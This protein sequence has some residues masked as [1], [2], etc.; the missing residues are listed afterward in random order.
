EN[1][2]AIG[3]LFVRKFFEEQPDAI[4]HRREHRKELLA[5]F[6]A[7]V[8]EAIEI[9]LRHLKR[10]MHRVERQVEEEWLRLVS[11]DKR[12][13][14]AREGVGEIAAF[15]IDGL[16]VAPDSVPP[17]VWMRPAEESEEFVEAALVR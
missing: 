12:D 16:L 17:E 10:L 7:N 13:R 4:V 9:I 6:I 1:Q 5:L 3:Q 14:F 11:I 2:R 15:V 8:G